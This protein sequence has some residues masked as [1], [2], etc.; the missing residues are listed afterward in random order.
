MLCKET[1][2]SCETQVFSKILYKELEIQIIKSKVKANID[3]VN[4]YLLK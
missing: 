2:W 3:H 4:P 1:Q